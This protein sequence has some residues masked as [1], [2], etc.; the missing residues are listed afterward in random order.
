MM[1]ADALVP[2]RHQGICNHHADIIMFM[3][4]YKYFYENRNESQL[5]NKQFTIR[6]GWLSQQPMSSFVTDSFIF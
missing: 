4:S 2:Y 3:V 6:G 1:V 5:L